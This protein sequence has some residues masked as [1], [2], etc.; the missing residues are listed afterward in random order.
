MGFQGLSTF[1]FTHDLLLNGGLLVK[2]LLDCVL[3][4]TNDP[5]GLQEWRGLL[6]RRDGHQHQQHE[7]LHPENTVKPVCNDHLQNKIYYLWFI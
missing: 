5:A 1:C 7:H 2:D 3:K 6:A 4:V